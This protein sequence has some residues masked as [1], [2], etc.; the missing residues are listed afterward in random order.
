MKT[1]SRLLI[2]LLCLLLT[3]AGLAQDAVWIDVRSAG[4]YAQGH[5][6][7][8]A[9]I[10]HDDIETGIQTLQVDKDTPILLYCRSG[11]RAGKAMER[12]RALGY[13]NV[14][15]LGGLEDARAYSRQ[16]LACAEAETP[17]EDCPVQPPA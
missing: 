11:N 4:E 16:L 15:N 17:T 10:P 5:L 3:P 1:L 9:L 13:T 8:A 2:P 7:G 6:D 14:T 12:L